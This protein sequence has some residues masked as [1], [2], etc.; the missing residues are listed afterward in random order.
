MQKNSLVL[1]R[2]I[3][4]AGKSTFAETYAY[5]LA[6]AGVD[7]AGPYEA[8]QY[9]IDADGN[10]NFDA[11]KLGSAHGQCLDKTNIAMAKQTKTV[12]VSNTFT[13][14]R[15]LTPYLELAKKYNY[16]V[17]SL[18]V[19]NRHGNKSIHDVPDEAITKMKNRFSVRLTND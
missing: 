13:T 16:Q 7:V 2:G 15:E 3:P 5:Q 17:V 10:Y 4:G 1:V 9:F 12:I 14:E 18:I 8:D 11:T 19:E 6:M